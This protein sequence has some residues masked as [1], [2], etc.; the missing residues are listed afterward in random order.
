MR[1]PGYTIFDDRP[2]VYA[3]IIRAEIDEWRAILKR[4]AISTDQKMTLKQ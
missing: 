1:D 3:E 4:K 2:E